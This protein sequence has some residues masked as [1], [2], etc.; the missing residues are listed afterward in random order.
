MQGAWGRVGARALKHGGVVREL[1]FTPDG[2][3]LVTASQDKSLRLWDAATGEPLAPPLE[4]GGWVLRV[5]AR[6]DGFGFATA[7]NDHMARL[8]EVPR[9]ESGPAELQALARRLNGPGR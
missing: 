2:H 3:V 6:P 5:D 1:A 7:G 8:W 4:H 9:M